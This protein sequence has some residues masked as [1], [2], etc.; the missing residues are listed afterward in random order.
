MGIFDIFTPKQDASTQVPV[1]Q[2]PAPSPSQ[3]GNLP[4]QQQASATQQTP[5]TEANGVVPA[6]QQPAVK[7]DD[8]PLAPFK[9]LWQNVPTKE[10]DS[11]APKAPAPLN[12]EDVQRAMANADFSGAMSAENLAAITAGGE[13]AATATAD[14]MAKVA[15]QVMVQST[16]VSNK[17]TEKAV[18]DAIAATEARIPAMLREQA[19]SSHLKDSNPLFADPAISPIVEQ[20][21]SQLLEK[22]PNDTPAETTQKLNNFINAMG[23]AFAPPK[24]SGTEAGATDWNKFL[25][26]R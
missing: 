1:N 6:Q 26:Q 21:R 17:L 23:E 11:G 4:A 7:A 15:Q 20:T 22:F 14:L 10:G 5:G 8:S 12:V 9:E 2:A 24:V 13:Q 16:M 3:P 25:T 18:A 19:T